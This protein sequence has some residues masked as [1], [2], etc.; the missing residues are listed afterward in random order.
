MSA[1][2]SKPATFEVEKA[3]SKDLDVSP[4]D[5]CVCCGR[6][7]AAGKGH[8]IHFVFGGPDALR[9][10]LEPADVDEDGRG[11]MGIWTIG[12][13]CARRVPSAYLRPRT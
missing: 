2:E 3:W 5:Q 4:S 7:V 6:D 13:E 12:P 10:D 1:L 9:R 8:D 11:D